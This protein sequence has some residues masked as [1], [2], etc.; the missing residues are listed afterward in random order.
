MN[1]SELHMIW[2]EYVKPRFS[3]GDTSGIYKLYLY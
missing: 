3:S 1:I 2:L